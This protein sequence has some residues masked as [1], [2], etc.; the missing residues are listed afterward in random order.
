[1][2]LFRRRGPETS[3]RLSTYLPGANSEARRFFRTLVQHHQNSVDLRAA[4]GAGPEATWAR[5]G[6]VAGLHDSDVRRTLRDVGPRTDVLRP[7]IQRAIAVAL[8]QFA[9][10]LGVRGTLVQAWGTAIALVTGL[11]VRLEWGSRL[12]G[13]RRAG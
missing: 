3:T 12:L 13:R 5:V 7:D 8:D 9:G 10:V 6:L 4:Q 11:V 1:M 2:A